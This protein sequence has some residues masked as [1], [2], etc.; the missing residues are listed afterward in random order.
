VRVTVTFSDGQRIEV[1][2]GA[3]RGIQSP[4]P[5]A[6]V[7]AKYRTLTDG[8]IDAPRRKA[9]EEMTLG[10]E[11]LGDVRELLALLAPPVAAAFE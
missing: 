6:E 9:I 3:S 4:L 10:I 11:D 7:L 2:R 1:D 8:L 5:V